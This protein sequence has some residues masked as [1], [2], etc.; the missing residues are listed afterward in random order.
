[1]GPLGGDSDAVPPALLSHFTR[2]N[3][4]AGFMRPSFLGGA[5][6]LVMVLK[7]VGN[8]CGHFIFFLGSKGSGPTATSKV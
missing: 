6:F 1:V 4:Q 3:C 7:L 5:H 8:C 2:Q